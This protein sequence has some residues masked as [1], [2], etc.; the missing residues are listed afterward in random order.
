[1]VVPER[2]MPAVALRLAVVFAAVLLVS[3]L[4]AG[5]VSSASRGAAS[6]DTS[7]GE[8]APDGRWCPVYR[9]DFAVPVP[10]GTFLT[11][12]S[13]HWLL[14][15]TNPYAQS[16]RS[17][18]DGWGTTYDR[19]LNFASRIASVSQSSE[20]VDGVFTLNARSEEVEGRL[21]S[22]GGSFFA[23]LD[24]DGADE[25]AQVAQTYGRY[26][27]RFRTTGGYAAGTDP[28]TGRGYGT[29]FLLWPAS[30]NWSEG[31]VDFPEMA[32]G[33][34]ISGY[35]HTIGDPAVNA[36]AFTTRTTTDSGWLTATIEWTP[37][38]LRFLVDDREVGRTTESVPSTPFRW[39]FQSGGMDATPDPDVSG[40]L[41]IDHIQIDAYVPD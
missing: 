25:T 9:E 30:N 35:V 28:A 3:S 17:Y 10:E 8:A 14:D 24:P 20:G 22:L 21:A 18:P 7:S 38:L 13:D 26:T 27:V 5:A 37:N 6:C 12:R 40:S 23:V 19:S 33:D 39:G 16:L 11:E 2:R 41:L 1:M 32:W 15:A 29:A 4:L 31:E 36:E 34:R